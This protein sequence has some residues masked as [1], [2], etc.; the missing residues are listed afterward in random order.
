MFTN[1]PSTIVSTA[2]LS[3]CWNISYHVL[4]ML[5]I[6]YLF[7]P[8][9]AWSLVLPGVTCWFQVV[10]LDGFQTSILLWG[11]SSPVKVSGLT[12]LLQFLLEN[13]WCS[14]SPSQEQSFHLVLFPFLEK[15]ICWKHYC[16]EMRIHK[17]TP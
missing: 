16:L 8:F 11:K 17:I 6:L 1:C 13:F 2:Y 14:F 15:Y 7:P 4:L 9:D 10:M 12:A 5:F 3:A